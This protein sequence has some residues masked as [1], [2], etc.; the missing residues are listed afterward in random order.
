MFAI[1]S[2]PWMVP[3]SPCRPWK[4]GIA[5]SMCAIGA[6]TLA[7]SPARCGGQAHRSPAFALTSRFTR[8]MPFAIGLKSRK[9][10]ISMSAS[11]VYHR[12]SREM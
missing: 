1:S 7:N 4:T 12:P 2:K 10:A 8:V 11:P 9:V 3:S 5:Q 6:G